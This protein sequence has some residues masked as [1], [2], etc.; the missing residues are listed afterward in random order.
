MELEPSSRVS[1]RRF[2][3]IG[4]RDF[5]DTSTSGYYFALPGS[6]TL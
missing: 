3:R 2:P 6:L 4:E 1:N 5:G